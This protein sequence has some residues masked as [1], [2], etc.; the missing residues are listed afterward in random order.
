[1]VRACK[2]VFTCSGSVAN[3]SCACFLLLRL[4][5]LPADSSSLVLMT[6]TGRNSATTWSGRGKHYT[7]LKNES[8]DI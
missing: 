2:C 5:L 6:A 3:D 7:R 4:L 1:M 8:S